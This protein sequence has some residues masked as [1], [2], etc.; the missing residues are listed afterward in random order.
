MFLI[1]KYNESI[2]VFQKMI[3]ITII[4]YYG[5]YLFTPG[6]ITDGTWKL[7]SSSNIVMTFM[8]KMP[9]IYTNFK[10]GST[11]QTAFITMFI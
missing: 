2:G 7:I 9:Q 6:L 5:Y 8:A 3:V 10:S 1:W 4:V 11:G